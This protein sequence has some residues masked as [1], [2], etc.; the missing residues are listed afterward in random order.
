MSQKGWKLTWICK[1]LATEKTRPCC[2]R[3]RK[4]ENLVQLYTIMHT[5]Y[6]NQN[7]TMAI[8][9]LCQV[10]NCHC[11]SAPASGVVLSVLSVVVEV[12]GR[13]PPPSRAGPVGN[14]IWIIPSSRVYQTRYPVHTRILPVQWQYFWRTLQ[15]LVQIVS[16]TLSRYQYTSQY[17][18]GTYVS[19]T[20]VPGTGYLLVMES[21]EP[22]YGRT[23]YPGTGYPCTWVCIGTYIVLG[24]GYMNQ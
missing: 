24:P 19:G 8:L 18:V 6:A 9:F 5:R 22:P 12:P 10:Y 11:K 23:R 16:E 15:C 21:H 4:S 13:N 7:L 20:W 17:N 1:F 3:Y 14:L 2:T